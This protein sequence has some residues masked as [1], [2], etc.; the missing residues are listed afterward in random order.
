M[1]RGAPQCDFPQ[2]ITGLS[3]NTSATEL[4]RTV[5][6]IGTVDPSISVNIRHIDVPL[7]AGA[8]LGKYLTPQTD[9]TILCERDIK[10][11]EI[12]AVAICRFTSAVI[13][14][15]GVG[16][17]QPS[18]LPSMPGVTNIDTYVSRFRVEVRG[19]NTTRQ[20]TMENTAFPVGKNIIPDGETTLYGARKGDLIFPVGWIFDSTDTGVIFDDLLFAVKAVI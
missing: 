13:A 1:L 19:E 7:F 5:T 9:G 14:A 20:V 3:L 17:G 11:L 8:Q 2:S 15:F 6:F 16:I 12:S 18:D 10:Y 4:S